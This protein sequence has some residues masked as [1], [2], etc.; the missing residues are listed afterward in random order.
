MPNVTVNR[1]DLE[2]LHSMIEQVRLIM[3]AEPVIPGGVERARELLATAERL[4]AL[5]AGD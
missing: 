5:L 4:A 2:A 1:Q 3:D